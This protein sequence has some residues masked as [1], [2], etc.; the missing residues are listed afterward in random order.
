TFFT[1]SNNTYN[2]INK[3]IPGQDKFGLYPYAQ[4]ADDRGK[5]LPVPKD[6]RMDYLDTAGS[7]LLPGWLYCPLDEL[8]YADNS[9]RLNDILLKAN[10]KYTTNIGVDISVSGQYEKSYNSTRYYYSDNSYTYR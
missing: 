2:G 4:L 3:I 5:A 9:S 1:G 8:G 6:Y 10:M 7:G